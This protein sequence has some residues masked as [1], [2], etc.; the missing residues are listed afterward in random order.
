MPHFWCGVRKFRTTCFSVEP[1]DFVVLADLARIAALAHQQVVS[2][3]IG[4]ALGAVDDQ[5]VDLLRRPRSQ[6]HRGREAGAAQAADTSLA[7]QR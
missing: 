1:S 3:D 5:R 2:G 4:L 6:F 7:N